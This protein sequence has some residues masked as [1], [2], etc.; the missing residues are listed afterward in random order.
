MTTLYGILFHMYS[1]HLNMP[2]Y[3]NLPN[4]H[5]AIQHKLVEYVLDS[6]CKTGLVGVLYGV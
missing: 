5:G 2:I 3:C 4:L 6:P 1:R